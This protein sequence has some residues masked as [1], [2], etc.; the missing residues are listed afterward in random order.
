MEELGFEPRTFR[1]RSGHST[2]EL[3]PQLM[4][5]LLKIY[6]ECNNLKKIYIYIKYILIK[7]LKYKK[8]KKENYI[9][10]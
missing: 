9:Y 8:K 5:Q 1:M 2:T 3:H 6:K 7:L 4:K 10:N